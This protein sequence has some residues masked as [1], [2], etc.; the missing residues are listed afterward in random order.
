MLAIPGKLAG[1]ENIGL[2]ALDE[3]QNWLLMVSTIKN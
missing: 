3:F 2:N 1:G